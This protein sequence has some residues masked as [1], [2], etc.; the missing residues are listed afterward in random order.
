MRVAAPAVSRPDH[1]L[2]GL[3]RHELHHD[4]D[5]HDDDLW[6]DDHLRA[7]LRH[8]LLSLEWIQLEARQ[9]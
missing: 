4:H 1:A 8:L 5:E 3:R 9:Y 7:E 6:A 2:H